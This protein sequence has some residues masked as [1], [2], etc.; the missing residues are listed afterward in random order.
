MRLRITTI[1]EG[2]S[3]VVHIDGQLARGGIAELERECRAAGKPIAIDLSNLQW[4]D[5][6]G[7]QWLR[8]FSEK[9]V[10]LRCV[11]PFVEILLE[12]E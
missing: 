7:I 12:K 11:P 2:Q 6:I 5:S 10:Q 4:A 9:G 3:N 8:K 1:T